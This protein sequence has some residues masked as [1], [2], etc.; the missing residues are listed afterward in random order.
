MAYLILKTS[1]MHFAQASLMGDDADETAKEC[2]ISRQDQDDFAIES[3]R[4]SQEAFKTGMFDEEIVS[5]SIA[6]RGKEP[7]VFSVDEEITNCVPEKVRA[8][9]PAFSTDGTVTAANASTLS[10]GASA[11]V[12]VS[13]EKLAEL[14]LSPLAEITSWADAAREPARFTLA[15]SLAIPKALKRAGLDVAGV[16]YWEL[17]E[18]FSVVA[19]ANAKIVGIPMDK[20]NVFG[21]G[22]SQGHPLGS[23]GSR[24]VVTL[25]SVLRKRQGKVGCAAVCNGGGGASSI[26]LKVC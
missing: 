24:I 16:D 22:V 5:V 1:G 2:N 17:N 4:R 3:Y 18:A 12:L 8:L 15:P 23:S 10:D 25:I 14:G 13:S 11:L 21:G 20:I 19:A 7:L 26:V 6:Q 9:R